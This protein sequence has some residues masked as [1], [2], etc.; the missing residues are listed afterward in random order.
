M[1]T[2]IHT[3]F[4]QLR[5]LLLLLFFWSKYFSKNCAQFLNKVMIQNLSNFNSFLQ[6]LQLAGQVRHSS[7]RQP[8]D[9]SS[10]GEGK[11][12]GQRR[13]QEGEER[14]GPD[15]RQ[16]CKE[17]RQESSSKSDRFE[18]ETFIVD[19]CKAIAV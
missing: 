14:A 8:P 3:R 2:L 4:V 18:E 13:R 19:S 5:K 7:G 15:P 9:L 10:D 12:E 17:T 16:V 6:I 1:K 11:Q